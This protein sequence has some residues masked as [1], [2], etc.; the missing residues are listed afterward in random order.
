M[1]S[2]HNFTGTGSIVYP[3]TRLDLIC[4]GNP[5]GGVRLIY[6]VDAGVATLFGE[7]LDDTMTQVQLS[8]FAPDVLGEYL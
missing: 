2:V 4:E 1:N 5:L 3:N 8:V 7:F 6:P